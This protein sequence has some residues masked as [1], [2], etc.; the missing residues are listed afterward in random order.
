MTTTTLTEQSL[1]STE[2]I[3]IKRSRLLTRQ[4][5]IKR[6][7]DPTQNVITEDDDNGHHTYSMTRLLNISQPKIERHASEPAPNT[8]PSSP[9][10]LTVPQ[11]YLLK[12][13]SHPLLVSQSLSADIPSTCPPASVGLHRQ[14][15]YPLPESIESS[16]LGT[17]FII[18][19]SMVSM[20]SSGTASTTDMCTVKTE[21]DQYEVD[22][23][24]IVDQQK[25]QRTSPSIV[26]VS[27]HGSALLNPDVQHTQKVRMKPAKSEELH[28]SAST[29]LV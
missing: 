2:S 10:L 24:T 20:A 17:Q 18:K 5:R 4:S 29:P 3:G 8:I 14:L 7:S 23:I 27:E 15:S 11:S 12:Q 13:H 1:Q 9:Q 26:V 16:S 28:R 19:P 22:T 25:S 21:S 6:D